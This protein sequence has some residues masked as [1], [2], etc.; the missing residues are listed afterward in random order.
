MGK[1]YITHELQFIMMM[2]S[3][4]WNVSCVAVVP[5]YLKKK[6]LLSCRS[7][8]VSKRKRGQT[9]KRT[10]VHYS[11]SVR[12]R[13]AST[14]RFQQAWWSFFTPHPTHLPSFPLN[15]ISLHHRVLVRVTGFIIKH[16]IGLA[17]LCLCGIT[18]L[19]KTKNKTKQ[20]PLYSSCTQR[21][22]W[23]LAPGNI[24]Y[25]NST[26]QF[27]EY[28]IIILSDLHPLIQHNI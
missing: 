16:K 10:G 19:K 21:G 22:L 17:K 1:T 4:D 8:S 20:Q 5:W 27:T 15:P 14:Q 9:E 6:H 13:N 23:K 26:F 12:K 25:H 2:K 18:Q 7:S 3:T 11:C 28:T 24:H